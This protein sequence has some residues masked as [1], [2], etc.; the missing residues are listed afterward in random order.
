M[1]NASMTS[2][3]PSISLTPRLDALPISAWHFWMLVILSAVLLCDATDEFLIFS[4]APLL[5]R[6]WGIT[7]VSVGFLIA[8]TG[9]GGAIGA[10]IFGAL[11]DRIGRRRCLAA[12]IVL[13]SL[14][15]GAAALAR[16]VPELIVIRLLGGIGIGG[17]IPVALAFLGEYSPPNW[18]G[19]F[20]AWW[21][22]M[23]A[24][25]VTLAGAVGVF[26]IVPYGWRWGFII[27]TT[28]LVL[29]VFVLWLPE[30]V[31]FLISR[32]KM[33]EALETTERVERA[34]LGAGRAAQIVAARLASTT[35]HPDIHAAVAPKP[36]IGG[37]R[38]LQLMN[39]PEIRGSMIAS[40]VLWFL[41]SLV[42]LPSFY[43]IFLTQERGMDVKTAIALV[44]VT[45]ILGPLGQLVGGAMS[46]WL[47]RKPT[48]A[49][50]LFLFGATPFAAF[51]LTNSVTMMYVYL[52]LAFIGT[53]VVYGVLFGYTTEQLPTVLRGSGLGFFEG[54]R[55]L[56]LVL[57]PPMIGVLYTLAGLGTVLWVA[58]G[59]S[60]LTALVLIV[61]GRET[62]GMP[63]AEIENIAKGR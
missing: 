62:R 15:T 46:D 7:A 13:F 30:S 36:Q 9:V 34:V 53:S 44:T 1:S 25:G 26:V 57:G 27:G 24:F 10:V 20:I 33:Q 48:L 35:P 38:A 51:E 39:T 59:C 6:E 32:G 2:P 28:P 60:A 55:R 14:L 54:L 8:A 23:F 37:K 47:G 17:V 41:P 61:L 11:A 49:F 40:A 29:V 52:T 3:A 5:I 50:G 58:L 45:S 42:L 4:M 43:P 12:S 18:R 16:N 21:N 31:R 22:S 56:G 19:R 63:L